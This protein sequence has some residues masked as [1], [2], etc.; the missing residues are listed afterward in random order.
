MGSTLTTRLR[1][2]GHFVRSIDVD[3]RD[4]AGVT[5][6]QELDDSTLRAFDAVIHLAGIS[7]DS[8][9]ESNPALAHQI[10]VHDTAAFAAACRAAGVRT[11]ILSSSAAIYGSTSGPATEEDAPNPLSIYAET[12]LAAETRLTDLADD[13]F[14]MTFARFGSGFGWSPAPRLD[15]V[16]NKL[17]LIGVRAGSLHLSDDGS[18]YR[19]FIHVSDMTAAL[20]HLALRGLGLEGAAA[21]N[22][23]HPDGNLT[24]VDAV[25]RLAA[26]LGVGLE[27]NPDHRDVRS[28]QADPQRLLDSGF[29]FGRSIDEG[30][31]SLRSWALHELDR[32]HGTSSAGTDGASAIID[33]RSIPLV[34][35]ATL[36][37]TVHDRFIEDV[38]AIVSTS[39]YRLRAGHTDAAT[40]LVSAAFDVPSGMRTMLLR[41]GTD[42]LMRSL[43]LVETRPGERVLVPDQAFHAVASSV[44]AVG[45]EPVPVDIRDDD[46]NLC[47]DALSVELG[48]GT[49]AAVIAV[50]NYGT[51]CD[52][53]EL[54]EVAHANG[55]PLIVDAC[56]SLGA[57]RD[58]QSVCTHADL[59]VV[60]FSFTKPIHAAGMGGALIASDNL[61]DQLEENPEFM[62][63]QL[64]M[65]E[66]NA[67][68]LRRIWYQIPDNIARLR[69]HYAQYRAALDF[70]GFEPQAEFG[71]STRIH[72]PF[73]GP[74]DWTSDVRD[75]VISQLQ[76]LGIGAAHQFPLQSDL[77]D[78]PKTCPTARA[79]D[80]RM[81]SLPTGVGL[82]GRS[83]RRVTAAV[84]ELEELRIGSG[85]KQSEV[86][87]TT[88]S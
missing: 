78:L 69:E 68:Y 67:A 19:P 11:F 74:P 84:R 63:R 76:Q 56:E 57:V 43:Q 31:R 9:A 73:L 5:R 4:H 21:V 44:R 26:V 12:K 79:I 71:S 32:E 54:S 22:I 7:C 15:L 77:L 75:T 30:L 16:L 3:D 2:H 6:F 29:A 72:A 46:F 87:G 20:E 55:V 48:R 59:V 60:S 38:S 36:P 52:W 50:D 83:I 39:R 49:A 8:A 33:L 42:A 27:I 86:T 23:A 81:I 17:A 13:T 53:A 62:C 1:D 25:T 85:R 80:Q 51:P 70:L 34:S 41:S 64:R 58:G 61:M 10:N 37:P 47:A 24:V 18:A 88:H 14:S 28:Y 45:A 40:D 65:P 82:D 35:P 66:L